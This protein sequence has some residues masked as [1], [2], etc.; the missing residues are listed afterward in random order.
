MPTALSLTSAPIGTSPAGVLT[1]ASYGWHADTCCGD[2][3]PTLNQTG[4]LK[5][6]I[7]WT[8]ACLSSWSKISAS[9]GVAK[10]PCCSPAATYVPTTLSTSCLRLHSRC[11]VPTAPRKYFVVTML[12]A[13]T[14]QKSGNSTPCCSKLTV[15]SR[16]LVITTSR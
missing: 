12:A 6:K 8:S 4:E 16:Q 13:L 10:Y 7:W 2:V 3:V 11:E 1:S 14:D 5:L 15:P 9:F